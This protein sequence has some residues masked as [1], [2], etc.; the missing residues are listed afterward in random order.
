MPLA[1]S[2]E[3]TCALCGGRLGHVL[4]NGLNRC[5][6]YCINS[7]ALTLDPEPAA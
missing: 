3:V 6:R 7:V 1:A 2:A 4:P 5:D